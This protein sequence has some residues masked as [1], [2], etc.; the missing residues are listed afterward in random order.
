MLPAIILS[1]AA[2]V[3]L[4]APD[5]PE[6]AAPSWVEAWEDN[7]RWDLDLSTRGMVD[8]NGNL[9]FLGAFGL[10]LHKVFTGADGRD[11]STL[12][13]QP[14]VLRIDGSDSPPGIFDS[15][16]DYA[17][18]WRIANLNV[19]L[20]ERG[21]LNVRVGHFEIPFGLEQNLDTNGTLRRTTHAQNFGF[22]ADWGAT[23]NGETQHVD[24]EF[25]WSRGSG[26]DYEDEGGNGVFSG[27]IGTPREDL[28]VY[29]LSFAHGD[30][31]RPGAPVR[32]TRFA[33]DATTSWR[34]LGFQAEV[35]AGEVDSLGSTR[36]LVEVNWTNPYE[37]RLGWAQLFGATGERPGADVE[38]LEARV[39]YRVQAA[40][41]WTVSAQVNQPL[42]VDD[43]ASKDAALT[44]QLR[45][46]I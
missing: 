26:N 6:A 37:T 33:V 15:D 13:F 8:S 41:H 23:L 40:A 14:Y 21:E 25:G 7:L 31:L 32:Q 29:G 18:Q 17:L 44:L 39:G 24:Y 11:R 42:I 28:T 45:V 3:P 2:V 35:S 16:H 9:S 27:R 20:R 22:I 36:A 4:Q 19:A 34:S 30:F 38:T 10:D 5:A 46:R 1:L 12:I 43:G